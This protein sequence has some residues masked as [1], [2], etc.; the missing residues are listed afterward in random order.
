MPTEEEDKFRFSHDRYV[1]A[2]AALCDAYDVKEMHY[3]V[4]MAAIKHGQF[5]AHIS[6]PRQVTQI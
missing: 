5:C 1:A 3:V 4:A 6:F 2:A